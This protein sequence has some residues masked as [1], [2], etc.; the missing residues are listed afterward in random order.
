MSGH[1]KWSK[2]KRG[3]EIKDRQ[4]SSIFSKLSRIIT[5][6]VV[7]GGGITDPANNIKLR[8]AV[9]KAKQL[10]MPKD[11]IA[12]AIDNGTGPDKESIKEV[13]YEAFA[14]GGVGLLIEA[15]TD[16]LNRTLSEVRNILELNGGKLGNQGSVMYL[17]RKC[18]L[19]RF[20][21]GEVTEEKVLSFAE[22][23]GAFD[24]DKSEDLFSVYIPFELL[25]K[26]HGAIPPDLKT[27]SIEIEFKPQTPIPISGE[28]MVKSIADL[29]VALEDLDDVH[30][31]FINGVFT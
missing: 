23:I 21:R 27:D 24:I 7:E 8:L 11:N 15:S 5:L 28:N 30:K 31:V 26:V 25:H 10:N 29:T 22:K 4:K 19:V 16:N 17:F 14:P 6:A 1:S 2:I 13:V 18:G 12:R 3:K 9:E 20:K